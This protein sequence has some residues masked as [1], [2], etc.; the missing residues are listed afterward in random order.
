MITTF[1]WSLLCSPVTEGHFTAISRAIG[2]VSGNNHKHQ[3]DAWLHV[4][5]QLGYLPM[6]LALLY[7]YRERYH[8]HVQPPPSPPS[9]PHSASNNGTITCGSRVDAVVGGRNRPPVQVTD[10]QKCGSCATRV[11]HSLVAKMTTNI[12]NTFRVNK[13]ELESE[14][15]LICMWVVILYSQKATLPAAHNTHRFTQA[16]Q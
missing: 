13:W 7:I 6:L 15:L 10:G 8:H 11:M 1:P 9:P 5:T 4:G 14:I 3:Q 16:I 2:H 12:S